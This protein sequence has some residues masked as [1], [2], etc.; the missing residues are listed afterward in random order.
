VESAVAQLGEVLK[1]LTRTKDSIGKATGFAI[2]GAK[3]GVLGD[4]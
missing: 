2:S 3:L 4:Q 1:G